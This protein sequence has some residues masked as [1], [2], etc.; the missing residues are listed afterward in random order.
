[1]TAIQAYIKTIRLDPKG[2]PHYFLFLGHAYRCL[3]RYEEAIEEYQKAL[4]R[5]PN[6]LFSHVHLAATYGLNGNIEMAH[7]EAEAVPR[8]N[9]DFSLNILAKNMPFKDQN[10][11]DRIIEGMRM[12]GLPD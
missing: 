7:A 1:L 5:E 9:P 8:I 3:K 2:T 11:L 12:A 10:C 6:H 4:D